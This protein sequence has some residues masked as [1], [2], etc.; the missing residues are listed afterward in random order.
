MSVEKILFIPLGLPK[1]GKGTLLEQFKA[2]SSVP[3]IGVGDVCREEIS[4][5]TERAMSAQRHMAQKQTTLWPTTE[6]FLAFGDRFAQHG[7]SQHVFAD[8]LLRKV[9]QVPRIH[10]LAREYSFTRLGLIHINTSAKDCMTR[11]KRPG[12]VDEEE[13]ELFRR[14]GDF[15]KETL[16]A[17]YDML[18]NYPDFVDLITVNGSHMLRDAPRYAKSICDLYGIQCNA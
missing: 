10:D 11:P 2:I 5:K 9:D 1:S 18:C 4:Q 17:L 14:I 3:I 12:R 16:P 13:E 6:L 8:G 15:E 7:D